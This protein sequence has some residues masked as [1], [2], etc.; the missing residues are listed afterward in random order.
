MQ[1][2]AGATRPWGTR[3]LRSGR[4]P[5][6]GSARRRPQGHGPRAARRTGWAPN[7]AALCA[8]GAILPARSL[9]K[10][11][12]ITVKAVCARRITGD[13]QDD[14]VHLHA[15]T[16]LTVILAR[17]DPAPVGTMARTGLARQVQRE[18]AAP[19]KRGI[20]QQRPDCLSMPDVPVW[21]GVSVKVSLLLTTP[22]SPSP[23]L[24]RAV[25]PSTP[26]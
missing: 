13:G 9:L 17:F 1:Q 25:G 12:K 3:R 14:Q 21:L 4:S 7:P 20:V 11:T 26:A 24:M 19:P 5:Y 2:K 8:N 16:T 6:R 23:I 22:V 10:P 18:T 15:K